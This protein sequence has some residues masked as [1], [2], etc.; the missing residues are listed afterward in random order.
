MANPAP[1]V[2]PDGNADI[3]GAVVDTLSMVG[4]KWTLLVV[5]TLSDGPLRFND[6][7]RRVGSIS[8]KVLS[9]TLKAL[10]RDGL[11]AR[12]VH[13][14]TP[15]QVTYELTP[16]GQSLWILVRGLA[17]WTVVNSKHIAVAREAYDTRDRRQPSTVY[18]PSRRTSSVALGA[19]PSLTNAST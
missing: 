15:P 17:E 12:S 9:G 8:Q 16:L 13:P 2:R 3:C 19:V 1:S 11:V 10:E 18:P 14:S 7:R 6:L 5:R 4:E